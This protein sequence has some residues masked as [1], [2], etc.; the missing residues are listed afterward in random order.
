MLR[1]NLHALAVVIRASRPAM[2]LAAVQ[3][4]AEKRLGMICENVKES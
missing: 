3:E 4:R 2:L 1:E